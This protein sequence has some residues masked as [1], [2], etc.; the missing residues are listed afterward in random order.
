MPRRWPPRYPERAPPNAREPLVPTDPHNPLN[1][2]GP[3]G[4]CQDIGLML[5]LAQRRR[6]EGWAGTGGVRE[7]TGKNRQAGSSCAR[8]HRDLPRVN[9]KAHTGRVSGP[10]TGRLMVSSRGPESSSDSP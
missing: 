7:R 6:D 3:P 10:G 1:Q 8:E 5:R 4:R 9:T 2:V